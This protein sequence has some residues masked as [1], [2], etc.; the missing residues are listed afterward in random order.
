MKILYLITKSELGGAQTYV[1]QLAEYFSSQKNEIAVMSFPGG[2]LEDKMIEEKIKFYPNKYFTNSLNLFKHLK[3][4]KKIK[5]VIKIFKPDIIH[6]NSST[7]GFLGRIVI[8]NKVPALF[9]AHGWAFT[10]GVPFLRKRWAI[11]AEKFIS[12]YCQKIICVSEFDKNL[13][14][15]YK[16]TSENKL[17][18]I[19]HGVKIGNSL[20][21]QRPPKESDLKSSPTGRVTFE[22]QKIIFIG[23]LTEPKNPLLLL[24]AFN[25]LSP[26]L[27]EKSE[28]IIVGEGSK[29]KIL[30]KFIQKNNLNNKIKLLGSIPRDKVFNLLKDSHIFVLT[31]NYEG[32][33][34][35]ILEAMSCGL[36]IIATD[37]NGVKEA[38]ENC[39]FLVKKGSREEVKECLKKLLENPELTQKIGRKCREKVMKEF[40]LEKMLKKTE[41]IYQNL[42]Y[43]VNAD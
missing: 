33:P 5:E 7:A 31:T 41:E 2:W 42:I 35:T 15:K 17:I 13:A 39:G 22:Y 8:K 28:I 25:D 27:K 11:L 19:H 23:R 29:R 24:K 16:I 9:T 32:L 43:R 3:A 36:A 21:D 37:V 4:I 20:I 34:Y 6:C 30:E 40:S 10:E 38:V 1:A 26:L 18:V 14:L 12:R